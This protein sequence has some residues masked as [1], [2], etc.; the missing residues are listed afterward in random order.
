LE[1][2]GVKSD[3]DGI[4]FHGDIYRSN[5]RSKNG[6]MQERISLSDKTI[7]KLP[8]V[9][10]SQMIVRDDQLPGFF[11]VVGARSRTFMIQADLRS[12]AT[13][14]SLRLKIGDAS[15][16]TTR[17]ARARAKVLLGKIAEGTD[18]R[19]KEDRPQAAPKIKRSPTLRVAWKSYLES[20]LQRK[21]RAQKT[22]DEYQDHVDRLMTD[23]L[24][25]KLSK[26]GKAPDLIKAKHDALT[27]NSGPYQA[28]ACMRTFRAVYNHARKTARSLPAENPVYAVD[29][30]PEKRRNSAL[31]PRSLRQWFEQ[32]RNINNPV[33]R[34]LHLFLLLSGSRPDPIK[35]AK[36]DHTNFVARQ[37]FIP[38]PKGGEDRAFC[39][40][41]S[42]EMMRSL[43]RAMRFGCM[44]HPDA[45]Q[46]WL[47]P[48]KS[49]AGHIIEHS[50]DRSALSHWGNDLRQ[51]YRTL[52]QA[53]RAG[54]VDMNL[55]MNHSTGD[56]NEG[57]ITRD[58]LVDTHLMKMQ[59]SISTS[60]FDTL[61]K[62]GYDQ[63][64]WGRA[65]LLEAYALWERTI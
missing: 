3:I 7:A 43:V 13:R 4:N 60:I 23:W 22:I 29:W 46:I 18:P 26:L 25:I 27:I 37:L 1:C 64:G 32:V 50:E 8:L 5:Y 10:G 9:K 36:L 54:K 14:Q 17:E 44:M 6:F 35:K 19:P 49:K 33:R 21:G 2:C 11:L 34:E 61:R 20:H 63:T 28:N 24:D 42:R 39:I 38:C 48:A 56:V 12:G 31:G 47:F 52:G 45:A 51:S 16:I 55:L 41:L 57:Y 59:Q 30:N 53:A 62:S 58:V 15:R 65:A 40:P